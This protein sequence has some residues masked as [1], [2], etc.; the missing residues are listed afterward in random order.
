MW[1]REGKM[2]GRERRDRLRE[3]GRREGMKIR[4]RMREEEEGEG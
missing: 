1:E 3:K 4:L 2:W